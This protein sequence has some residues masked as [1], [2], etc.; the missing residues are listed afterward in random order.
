MAVAQRPLHDRLVPI[1][2]AAARAVGRH[3]VKE[4][5][6]TKAKGALRITV[7]RDVKRIVQV[8]WTPFEANVPGRS[9]GLHLEVAQPRVHW[10]ECYLTPEFSNWVFCFSERPDGDIQLTYHRDYPTPQEAIEGFFALSAWYVL[11][12]TDLTWDDVVYEVAD[13]VGWTDHHRGL[14]GAAVGKAVQESLKK[15]TILW[16]RWNTA[17][18]ERTMPVWYLYDN[19]ADKIY[20]L[21]GERQQFIPDAE[22]IRECEVIFRW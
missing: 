11:T 2:D 17:A 20:I 3:G 6:V 9:I 15:S 10:A 19:K 4:G 7:E 1:V 13:E 21:S 5:D 18:G 8:Y 12:A 22:N 14:S 16:L